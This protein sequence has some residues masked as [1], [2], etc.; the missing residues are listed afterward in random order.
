MGRKPCRS[1]NN[2]SD[3]PTGSQHPVNG[4]MA[5]HLPAKHLAAAASFSLLRPE[6]SSTVVSS[7]LALSRGNTK[8]QGLTRWTSPSATITAISNWLAAPDCEWT[9]HLKAWWGKTTRTQFY[10]V[11]EKSAFLQIREGKT[12]GDE[13]TLPYHCPS[14]EDSKLAAAQ[15]RAH[16]VISLQTKLG[17]GVFPN[18][19]LLWFHNKL[20]PCTISRIA[21][22]SALQA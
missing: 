4:W 6:G 13:P 7:Q 19:L 15:C 2:S 1:P 22:L 8:C 5:S 12:R 9:A 18:S 10:A 3:P 20:A 16:T 14:L 21:L 17:M 11:V